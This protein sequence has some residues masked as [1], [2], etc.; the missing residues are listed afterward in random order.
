MSFEKVSFCHG[1]MSKEQVE[2]LLLE[3]LDPAKVQV[4]SVRLLQFLN[5]ASCLPC[6]FEIATNQSNARTQAVARLYIKQVIKDKWSEFSVEDRVRLRQQLLTLLESMEERQVAT[7]CECVSV[8]ARDGGGFPELLVLFT[9]VVTIEK[10]LGMCLVLL[11]GI[12]AALPVDFLRENRDAFL[13]LAQWGAQSGST[14]LRISACHVSSIY[15]V[16]EKDVEVIRPFLPCLMETLKV[17]MTGEFLKSDWGMVWYILS[18][19]AGLFTPEIFV[20]INKVVIPALNATQD[21]LQ[22]EVIMRFVHKELKRGMFSDED[23]RQLL[24]II[25]GLC[26]Q[27]VKESKDEDGPDVYQYGKMIGVMAAQGTPWLFDVLM[28][29]FTSLLSQK[30]FV[31]NA[32][33]L[34]LL[35]SI[36][37]Y[38]PREFDGKDEQMTTILKQAFASRNAAVILCACLVVEAISES[39]KLRYDC[40]TT[41]LGAFVI[42]YCFDNN[43]TIALYCYLSFVKAICSS[44]DPNGSELLPVLLENGRERMQA[45]PQYFLHILSFLLFHSD[46]TDGQLSTVCEILRMSYEM[47]SNGDPQSIRSSVTQLAAS[48]ALANDSV[49]DEMLRS[50][51]MPVVQDL[52]KQPEIEDPKGTLFPELLHV[53][54]QI[55]QITKYDSYELLAGCRELLIKTTAASDLPLAVRVI[56]KMSKYWRDCDIPAASVVE[57]IIST[58]R[59]NDTASYD[60]LVEELSWID[61]LYPRLPQ[62]LIV[63]LFQALQVFMGSEHDKGNELRTTVWRAAAKLFR[64]A[65]K[66]AKELFA[67]NVIRIARNCVEAGD[68]GSIDGVD[69]LFVPVVKVHSQVVSDWLNFSIQTIDS[70]PVSYFSDLLGI[71]GDAVS[72]GTAD[73]EMALSILDKAMPRLQNS[74]DPAVEQNFV[75]FLNCLINTHPECLG[76]VQERGILTLV[77]E[78][79]SR[80]DVTTFVSDNIASLFLSVAIHS[81]ELHEDMLSTAL[82]H[83]PP[84]ELTESEAMAEKLCALIDKVMCG[85]DPLKTKFLVAITRLLTTP[86]SRLKKRKIKEETFTCL[87]NFIRRV[88]QSD[89]SLKS[90][91]FALYSEASDKVAKLQKI[92]L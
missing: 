7:M 46:I 49:K 92:M 44:A 70:V 10:H 53:V 45:N 18:A 42:P 71:F 9:S 75:Y 65:E 77:S 37:D 85:S 47:T 67:V 68:F 66:P 61:R 25:T 19:C 84:T 12:G 3:T 59:R 8:I 28:E 81:S 83:F 43:E 29:K 35:A 1:V 50:I 16:F 69:E 60:A 79:F 54:Q 88:A 80:S 36:V 20:E 74:S 13:S 11:S 40:L 86:E 78:W 2:N 72:A 32:V 39:T 57:K 27:A 58:M 90:S 41:K 34:V 30:D 56:E 82:D 26:Y 22:A 55:M 5:D 15:A 23:K 51:L 63:K 24:E 48:L 64:Y 17:M 31:A 33:G 62:E 38:F 87:S 91:L 4:A 6:L 52:V 76:V 14:F 73:K 89:P 21:I